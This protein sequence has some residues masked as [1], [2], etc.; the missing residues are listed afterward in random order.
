MV[1]RSR[2]LQGV[3]DLAGDVALDAAHD[4]VLRFTFGDAPRHVVAGGLVAA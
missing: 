2:R 4:F 3:E 1:G